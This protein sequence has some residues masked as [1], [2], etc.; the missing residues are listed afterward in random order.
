MTDI[1]TITKIALKA[2]WTNKLR[3]VLTSLGIIIG[4]SAVIVMLAIGEGAQKKISDQ[5]SSM[6]SIPL[7]GFNQIRDKVVSAFHLHFNITPSLLHAVLENH[8]AVVNRYQIKHG[9]NNRH[10][11]NSHCH[12]LLSLF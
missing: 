6:Q 10:Q 5:M 2:I 11:Q 7:N 12:F 3:S 1:L 9:Q 8:K 4:V